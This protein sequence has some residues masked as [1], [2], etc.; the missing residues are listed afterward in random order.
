MKSNQKST[1]GCYLKIAVI[2]ILIILIAF[3]YWKPHVPLGLFFNDISQVE[4]QALELNSIN[5]PDQQNA[6]FD[7][8][9]ITNQSEALS[10]YRDPVESLLNEDRW[11]QSKAKTILDKTEQVREV[12]SDAAQH[13]FFQDPQYKNEQ[14]VINGAKKDYKNSNGMPGS[15]LMDLN[16]IRQVAKLNSIRTKYL[17]K[18]QQYNNAVGSAL[19]NIKVGEKIMESQSPL[20]YF[21]VGQAIHKRGLESLEDILATTSEQPAELASVASRLEE[22]SI[23]GLSTSYKIAYHNLATGIDFIEKNG[24][25]SVFGQAEDSEVSASMDNIVQKEFYFQPNRT[26]QKIAN[27]FK[28]VIKNVKSGCR[29]GVTNSEDIKKYGQLPDEEWR[30]AFT[31]NYVGKVFMSTPTSFDGGALESACEHLDSVQQFLSQTDN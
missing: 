20:L 1:G 21:L 29:S 31:P 5:L 8:K 30:W 26:Q 2:S 9:Q 19:T 4:D 17:S 25:Q 28:G 23:S 18:N 3:T 16:S 12:Y 22:T 7:L 24:Y 10:Q 15:Y 13:E 11:S 27:H 6:Y 14:A